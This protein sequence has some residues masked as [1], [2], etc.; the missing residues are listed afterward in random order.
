MPSASTRAMRDVGV[1][2]VI[3]SKK[4]ED[5][6]VVA[7]DAHAVPNTTH[8]TEASLVPA[9][10]FPRL[11][12]YLPRTHPQE[13]SCHMKAQRPTGFGAPAP[14]AG[15][16]HGLQ[17]QYRPPANWSGN[18]PTVHSTEIP[19]LNIMKKFANW[20]V[21]YFCSFDVENGHPSMTCPTHLRKT[22]HDV[23][24]TQQN[25]QQYIALGHPCCTKN[26]HKMQFPSMRQFGAANLS[27]ASKCISSFY[28]NT[29]NTSYP[30]HILLVDDNVTVATSNVSTYEVGLYKAR[31][32]SALLQNKEFTGAMF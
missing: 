32:L 22:L 29:A 27:V 16:P 5:A 26:R 4:M 18:E 6:D 25:T 20:N 19:F 12:D 9:V 15:I 7:E 30:T 31:A 21:C 24:F 3:V 1:L 8:P 10:V 23:Y 11:Q 17:T 14:P 2:Q 28:V 13:E